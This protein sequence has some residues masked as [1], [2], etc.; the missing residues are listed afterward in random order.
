MREV[1]ETLGWFKVEMVTSETHLDFKLFHKFNK[2]WSLFLKCLLS[3]MF[4]MVH[5]RLEIVISDR[6]VKLRFS[7]DITAHPNENTSSYIMADQSS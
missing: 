6:L 4:E 2:K 5:E 3:T 1:L 7:R